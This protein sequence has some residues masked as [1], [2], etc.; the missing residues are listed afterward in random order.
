MRGRLT[1]WLRSLRHRRDLDGALDEELRFH[2][3][4]QI[5]RNLRAGMPPA[6]ARRHALLRFG[7]VQRTREETRDQVAGAWLEGA[8]HDLK[9]ACRSTRRSPLVGAAVVLTLALGVGAN[10]AIFG[11]LYQALI[12]PLPYPDADR[13]VFVWNTYRGL[14]MERGTVSIPDYLDRKR[15]APALADAALMTLGS[16]ALAERGPPAQVQVLSVTPSFFT[17]LQ[18]GP[19]LGRAFDAADDVPGADD[20][21]I[22]TYGVWASRFG[23]DPA[24][25]G[26]II[27]LSGEPRRV[28]GVLPPDLH[29]HFQL[30]WRQI[31]LLVP[32]AFTPQQMSDAER[33]NEFSVMIGRLAPGATVARLNEQIRTIVARNVER[34][35]QDLAFER[36][37]GFGGVAVP[38]HEQLTGH[39]AEALVVLQLGVL[40]ILLIASA[41][42]ANLLLI[43]ATG[44]GR[45]MAVRTALGASPVRLLRQSFAEAIV[46]S[47][48]GGVGGIAIGI[49]GL[50]VLLARAQGGDQIPEYV[51]PVLHWPVLALAACLLGVS[52]LVFGLTPGLAA[53]SRPVKLVDTTRGSAGRRSGR[54]RTTLVVAQTSL[55]VVLLVGAGLLLRSFAQLLDVDP[56]FSSDRVLTTRLTLPQS[57]YPDTRALSDVW[58]R[59]LAGVLP[60]P[61]VS[62]VGL[63]TIVPLTGDGASGAYRI[64]G[65]EDIEPSPT[66]YFHGVAGDYFRAMQI[67]LVAGRV[68]SD[69]D[70]AESP[71]VVVID[72]LLVDRYF[73]ERDPVGQR[74]RR[75]QTELT[76]VGVVRTIH[77]VDLAEPATKERIYYSVRQIPFLNRD[78]ALVVKTETDPRQIVGELRDVIGRIDPDLPLAD[79]Q[80]MDDVVAGSLRDRWTPTVLVGGFGAVALVLAALGLYSVLAFGVSQR[81]RE[82]G[83]RQALGADERTI[84]REVMV[85]GAWSVG[86]GLVFGLLATVVLTRYLQAL[87]FGVKA[88][89]L[90][91]IGSACLV[92]V[93]AAWLASYVPARRATRVDPLV[94]LRHE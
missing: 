82:L 47:V 16:A 49:L 3:D 77:P 66:A 15:Q 57:R 60:L 81:V 89:D 8:W 21:A 68:F 93:G 42:V 91:T 11:V 1:G 31:S 23:A 30:P 58:D 17:T 12:R 7:G 10:T 2:I 67:P 79:V 62:T 44:R 33:G 14:G 65:A 53:I 34:L 26:R 5:E 19:L 4:A 64:V 37:N 50:R 36:A 28:V 41:N 45:E 55:A 6:E 63:S 24:I 75:G 29:L 69:A 76:I 40:G 51:G 85:R 94:A 38:M 13:L 18:R 80:T 59:V 84:F 87:L 9:G 74:I 90:P 88:L 83:I 70:H 39:M 78:M 27:R 54:I 71:I 25:V 61:G 48:A 20:I 56:G 35:P 52:V 46:W 32:F 22:L 86:I 73:R 92:L 72:E 43:R